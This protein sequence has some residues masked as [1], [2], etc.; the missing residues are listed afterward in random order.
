M[1]YKREPVVDAVGGHVR[2]H[3]LACFGA[4]MKGSAMG[5]ILVMVAL[6]AAVTA[7]GAQAARKSAVH[8]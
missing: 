8:P 5:K 2:E 3:A 1:S 4:K 6:L 7:P